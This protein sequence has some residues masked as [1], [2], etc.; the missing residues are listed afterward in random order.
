M[1]KTPILAAAIAT[2]LAACSAAAQD[3]QALPATEPTVASFAEVQATPASYEPSV[4]CDVRI[5]R[6]NNGVLIQGRAFA[7]TDFD[8]EYELN[9]IKTGPNE[10]EI[11]QSGEVSIDSG[12]SITFGES[13]MSLQRGERLRAVLNLRDADGLLCRS[14]ASL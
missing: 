13:E 10:S 4:S 11:N 5:R 1:L 6:T 14:S 8:G 9:V 3:T 2:A 7:D 12:R